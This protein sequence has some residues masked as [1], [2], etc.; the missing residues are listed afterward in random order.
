[1][2]GPI[3][4]LRVM[5][6]GDD[7]ELRTAL[8]RSD[9]ASQKWAKAQERRNAA[10]RASFLK[11]AK[12][13]LAVATATTAATGVAIKYADELAKQAAT[14]GIT[15]S[16]LQEY[17][18]AAE[19]SGVGTEEMVKGLQ[20]FNKFVGQ[21]ARGTGTAKS[22]FESLGLRIM[23]TNG[24]MR[25]SATLIDEFIDKLAGIES[26]AMRAGLASDVFGRAGLSCCP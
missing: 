6:S 14:L 10:V 9:K 23:D 20:Q 3:A 15:T 25:P 26:P 5:L 7:A 13:V 17:T 19:R 11:V 8:G 18:F 21:A 16:Q 22:A 1:M 4:T 2:A 12:G 24:A